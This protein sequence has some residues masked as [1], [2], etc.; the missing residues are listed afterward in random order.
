MS[1]PKRSLEQARRAKAERL[2]PIAL[3]SDARSDGQPRIPE[4]DVRVRIRA[5]KHDPGPKRH[6]HGMPHALGNGGG[7]VGTS[8]AATGLQSNIRSTTSASSQ[9]TRP[10]RQTTDIGEFTTPTA[11]APTHRR[12]KRRAHHLHK[13]GPPSPDQPQLPRNRIHLRIR[14]QGIDPP[15]RPRYEGHRR[16]APRGQQRPAVRVQLTGVLTPGHEVLL[17]RRRD[18]HSRHHQR[19]RHMVQSFTTP[20]P[21]TASTGAAEFV[22]SGTATVSGTVNPDGQE[23]YY[24][25][26]TAP[27]PA[28]GRT[29]SQPCRRGNHDPSKPGRSTSTR[30]YPNT[31]YHYRLVAINTLGETDRRERTC[32][33]RPRPHRRAADPAEQRV[34]RSRTAE[35]VLDLDRG[36]VPEPHHDRT[37]TRHKRSGR[38]DTERN[39]DPDQGTEAHQ[40]IEAVQAEKKGARTKL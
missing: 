17:P 28:T 35:H 34:G 32:S 30:S 20:I 24:R 11:Q 6:N 38:N 13:R 31:T 33:S 7:G 2:D 3:R 9:Q 39:E 36:R 27:P 14:H 4:N 40:S 12:R 19:E 8:A 5:P 18:Q 29:R 25:S 21:P 15:Q 16:H 26:N 10:A 23:T 1:L 22:G 37:R